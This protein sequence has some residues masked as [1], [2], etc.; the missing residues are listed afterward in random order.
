MKQV[1]DCLQKGKSCRNKLITL[2]VGDE[3]SHLLPMKIWPQQ[4]HFICHWWP[5]TSSAV[6]WMANLIA[7]MI[8]TW[9]II[10]TICTNNISICIWSLFFEP[11]S[12]E[13]F[14]SDLFTSRNFG[15]LQWMVWHFIW[16]YQLTCVGC[17]LLSE[18]LCFNNLEQPFLELVLSKSTWCARL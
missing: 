10:Y 14:V 3:T 17:H 4:W 1:T 7:C 12:K 11:V 18:V 9:M 2:T 15:Q 8:I 16:Y 13:T 5:I 6:T